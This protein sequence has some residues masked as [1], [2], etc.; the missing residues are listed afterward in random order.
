[1][2]PPNRPPRTVSNPGA[3]KAVSAARA[4]PQPTEKAKLSKEALRKGAEN[5]ALNALGVLRDTW[6]D[7]RNSDRFFKYKAFVLATWIALSVA[8]F[9]VACPGSGPS[10]GIGATLGSVPPTV[11]SDPVLYFV[12]NDSDEPW[13]DVVIVVN[14]AYRIAVAQVT[15]NG[16][17][18]L[19]PK[20]LVGTDGV[21]PQSDLRVRRIEVRT[22]EGKTELMKDGQPR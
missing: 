1:M 4:Q 20:Q 17:V 10:N 19:S 7:F 2:A 6:D 9:V 18:T 22:A 16:Q 15:P 5:T 21:T 14:D 8:T 11:A 3:L 13:T 12:K